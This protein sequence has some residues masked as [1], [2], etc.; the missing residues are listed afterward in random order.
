M[1]N[2]YLIIGPSGVGKTTAAEG[3]EERYGYKAIKSYTTRPPRYEGEASHIFVDPFQFSELDVIAYNI[4]NGY[5][6]GITASLLDTHDIFVVE[7][8]G[9]KDVKR[10][11]CGTKGIKVIALTLDNES[12]KARM[13]SRGDLAQGISDRMS[14]EAEEDFESIADV[15]ISTD[16]LPEQVANDIAGYIELNEVDI[17]DFQKTQAKLKLLGKIAKGEASAKENGYIA[18]SEVEAVLEVS[19]GKH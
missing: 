16:K 14:E 12:L 18:I 10:R 9:V 1:K 3:L 19:D 8:S 7:P 13:K 17:E 4:K 5:E 15:V 2:V 11:Y 6:Y